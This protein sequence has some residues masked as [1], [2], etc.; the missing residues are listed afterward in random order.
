MA[1]NQ[2]VNKVIYGN[3]T[4]IDLT[5]D[6]VIPEVMLAGYTAHDASGEIIEG[7]I[8]IATMEEVINY[9]GLN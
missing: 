8:E 7:S 5:E 4:L 6:T 1:E 9:F 3:T 2:Y